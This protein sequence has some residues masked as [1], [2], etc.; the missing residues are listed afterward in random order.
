MKV[1]MLS[2]VK[3]VGKKGEVIEVADGYAK[4]FLLKQNLA[5]LASDTALGVLNKQKDDEAKKQVELKKEA[6]EIQELLK[7]KEFIFE[8]KADHGKVFNSVSNK[9]ILVELANNGFNLNKKKFID[10]Q[11]LKTLG[12]HLVKIELYKGVIGVIKILLKEKD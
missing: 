12:Y 2:D 4:N 7:T 10:S 3:K 5:V 6:L 1:I 9:Q 11:P 8:V